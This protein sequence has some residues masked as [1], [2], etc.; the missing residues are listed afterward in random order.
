[1][2]SFEQLAEQYTPMIYKIMNSLHIYKNRDEFFQL[3]FISLWE[4]LQRFD[5]NKGDFTNYAYTY[6]KGKFLS[7]MTKNSKHQAQTVYRGDEF[8]EIIEAPKLNSH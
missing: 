8:W 3:G 4:A 5:A 6:I 7:E 2:E 1:M